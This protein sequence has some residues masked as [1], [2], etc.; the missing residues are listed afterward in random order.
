MAT[1][2][3]TYVL[4][5]PKEIDL[6]AGGLVEINGVPYP[7]QTLHDLDPDKREYELV[8]KVDL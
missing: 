8:R 6:Q 4:V 1:N 7:I 5:T 3:L 2:T